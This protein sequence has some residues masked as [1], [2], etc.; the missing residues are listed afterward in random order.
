M[1]N[2][3]HLSES[4]SSLNKKWLS[5]IKSIKKLPKNFRAQKEFVNVIEGSHKLCGI[6]HYIKLRKFYKEHEFNKFN[7]ENIFPSKEKLIFNNFVTSTIVLRYIN[8]SLNIVLLF[9]N[10]VLKSQI[11]EVGA[12]YGGDCKIL[13]DHSNLRYNKSIHKYFIFDLYNNLFLIKKFLIKFNYRFIITSL[14]KIKVDRSSIFISNA[15]VSEMWGNQLQKYIKF[16]KKF[17]KG[18]LIVNFDTHS[19]PFG[20]ISLSEFMDIIKDKKPILLNTKSFLTNYDLR[21]KT[22][23]IVFGVSKKNLKKIEKKLKNNFNDKLI[24][25]F[26]FLKNI[27]LVDIFRILFKLITNFKTVNLRKQSQ[28]V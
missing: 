12:G 14:N 25:I 21:Q 27:K 20:G 5:Y 1:R 11:V 7:Y 3:T 9:Q 6:E 28:Q 18:Y 10:K 19:K 13:N 22:K 8:N 15:A 23:I 16:L 26:Y 24:F 2:S 4:A 17:K